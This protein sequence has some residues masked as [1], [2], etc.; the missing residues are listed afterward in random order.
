MFQRITWRGRRMIC[1]A[2][3]SLVQ[4]ALGVVDPSIARHLEACPACQAEITQLRGEAGLLQ[5]A[6]LGERRIETSDCLAEA[7]VADFVEGRLGPGERAPVVAHLLSCAR[8]RSTVAA[9]GRLLQDE[10][11]T[12][13]MPGG[14]ERD[15]K[16]W[17]L[18]IGLAAAAAV[19]LLVWPRGAPVVEPVPGLRDSVTAVTP[20]PTPLAPRGSVSQVNRFVWSSMPGIDRYRLRL[21]DNQGALRWTA[22]TPDT[23]SALPDSIVLSPSASYFWKVEGQTEWQRWSPSELVDFLVTGAKR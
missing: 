16:R 6:R 23:V 15:W 9:T 12:K 4:H 10:A 8:C 2:P 14:V 7:V 18:P 20:A 19:L 3:E 17:S 21:Y 5:A 22:E 1:P 13:A 11:V